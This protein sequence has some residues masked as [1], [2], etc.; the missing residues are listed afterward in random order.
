MIYYILALLA[1]AARLAPHPA[2]FA[3]VAALAMFIGATAWQQPT[4]TGRMAALILPIAALLI[5]DWVIGFYSWQVMVSVYAGF[6][7]SIILGLLIRRNYSWQTVFAASLTGSVI[8]FL[9]TNA[10]VWAF[11]PM[12]DKTIA[13]LLESYT[14][15]LPFFR[16]SLVGD[17]AY[18]AVLFGAYQLAGA[19]A[20]KL[21]NN[22]RIQWA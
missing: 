20:L 16:N 18:S 11:T 21:T 17:L 19:P 22:R 14:L 3:P 7:I 2:N 5:S 6:S 15:A 10:A 4:K 13:G 8:F 1:I 9:L 12:Y